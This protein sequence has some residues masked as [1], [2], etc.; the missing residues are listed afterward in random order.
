MSS[1]PT[2]WSISVLRLDASECES[3]AAADGPPKWRGEGV[4]VVPP[5][6]ECI[7]MAHVMY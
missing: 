2:S 7:S 5:V 6:I 4:S 1:C 3:K